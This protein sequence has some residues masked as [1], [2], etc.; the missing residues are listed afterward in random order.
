MLLSGFGMKVE[1]FAGLVETNGLLPN[2]VGLLGGCRGEI[3][4]DQ[5]GRGI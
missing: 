5:C 3:R 2:E 1:M 4:G